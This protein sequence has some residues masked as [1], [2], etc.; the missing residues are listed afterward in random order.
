[1]KENPTDSRKEGKLYSLFNEWRL[2]EYCG[3]PTPMDW[4]NIINEATNKACK[5]RE[6]L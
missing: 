2:K 6:T 3:D 4:V 1:M 5:K